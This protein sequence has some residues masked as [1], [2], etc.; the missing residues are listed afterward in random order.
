[1]NPFSPMRCLQN[2]LQEPVVQRCLG[3]QPQHRPKLKQVVVLGP[4]TSGKS[5]LLLSCLTGTKFANSGAGFELEHALGK[6]MNAVTWSPL[7][8]TAKAKLEL[9]CTHTYYP[10]ADAILFLVDADQP[11]TFAMAACRLQELVADERLQKAAFAVVLTKL[12]SPNVSVIEVGLAL[13][14]ANIAIAPTQRLE[15]FGSILDDNHWDQHE[16]Y[17][18]DRLAAWLWAAEPAPDPKCR[19]QP[20]RRPDAEW[21]LDMGEHVEMV[22]G[23]LQWVNA[24]LQQPQARQRRTES[25]SGESATLSNPEQFYQQQ[26]RRAAD[27]PRSGQYMQL[28]K[29]SVPTDDFT[30]STLSRAHR[31]ARHDC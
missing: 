13:G 14:V 31:D 6:G 1:M 18:F 11:D 19:E 29:P 15:I 26:R 20:Q 28:H 16:S 8:A 22:W 5:T 30:I 23:F 3:V 7:G 25:R 24:Q 10:S 4:S 9:A 12:N 17:G 21:P 27:A 2:V